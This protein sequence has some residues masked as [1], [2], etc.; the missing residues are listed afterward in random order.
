MMPALRRK[1]LRKQGSKAVTVQLVAVKFI[2]VI[3]RVAIEALVR[4]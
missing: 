1:G 3:A 2:D 4:R